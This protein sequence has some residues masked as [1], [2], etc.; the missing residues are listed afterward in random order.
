MSLIT[1]DIYN[2]ILM[3]PLNEGA[4]KLYIVSGFASSAMAFHHSEQ[5]KQTIKNN[6]NIELIIGMTVSEGISL[7]NH[8]AFKQL[9]TQD[10]T[11]FFKCSYLYTGKQ[12]HSKVYTWFNNDTPV[13]AYCGSAN[14]S[15]QAF[16]F[17]QRESFVQCDPNN[18]KEYFG[19]L[20][21]ETILCDHPD[22]EDSIIIYHDRAY[23]RRPVPP[24][25]ITTTPNIPMSQPSQDLPSVTVSFLANDGS[26]PERS[27]LNWGQRP[28]YR[29][30][31]NQA[32]IRLASDIYK[33]DFFPPKT[34]HFTVLTDDS[35]VLICT[36]AQE[37]YGKAIETPHNNSL[38]GEYF[39]HRLGVPNGAFV[40]KE[41]LMQYGRHTVTFFKIDTETYYMDFSRNG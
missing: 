19:S 40:T 23:T 13:I 32:Y 28:E 21:D 33:S 11:S 4:N 37:Q 39:R 31:P 27:G 25:T 14:Y 5:V 18:A 3:D 26:L 1:S 16:L 38:I 35:K 6:I 17:Q 2:K 9:A 30:N 8:R 10:L 22:V 7:S 41:H 36:R 29:R 34:V 24:E 15:Q 12:V 20:I